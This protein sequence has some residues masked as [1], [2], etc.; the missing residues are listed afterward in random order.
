MPIRRRD[1]SII[2]V[3]SL[4]NQIGNDLGVMAVEIMYIAINNYQMIDL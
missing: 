1:D 3:A 4:E 2:T